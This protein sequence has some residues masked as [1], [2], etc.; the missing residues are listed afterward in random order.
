[1]KIT[2]KAFY[3]LVQTERNRQDEKWGEQDH[4]DEKWLVILLE[5]LGEVSEAILEND[6]S[7]LLEETV[8]VAAVLENWIT[9]RTWSSK[10]GQIDPDGELE[11][12]GVSHA[13]T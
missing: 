9:S 6:D 1:M 2:K 7:A 13:K 3:D 4:S 11:D 5:E 8:Q 12:L 10:S